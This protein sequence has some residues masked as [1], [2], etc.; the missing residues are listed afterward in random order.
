[1]SAVTVE[2]TI[3]VVDTR[4]TYCGDNWA[5]VALLR[6]LY[7]L[8]TIVVFGSQQ[9]ATTTLPAID[10]KPA[11]QSVHDAAPD[12]NV[13]Y[14]FAGQATHTLAP[15][16]FLCVPPTH[17]TQGPPS[18]PVYP[19]LHVQ[20]RSSALPV[21]SVCMF[22]GQVVHACGPSQFLYV[23]LAHSAH[24]P[25]SGPVNP[26]THE[27]TVIPGTDDWFCAHTVQACTPVSALNV[28]GAQAT[29]AR[30]YTTSN[31]RAAFSTCVNPTLHTQLVTFGAAAGDCLIPA[32]S[33]HA[34]DP[35]AFLY[36]PATHATHTSPV[37]PVYPGA[38]PQSA[39]PT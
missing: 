19:V 32:Q 7:G 1:L 14:V 22:A 39:L 27:H 20:L 28:P 31:V 6:L 37:L 36:F 23:L 15:V 38:H 24:G 8:L 18:A 21:R 10:R 9:S 5:C 3:G 13:E 34:A 12:V 17:A 2:P 4:T 25:P 26:S 30:A 33:T 16:T 29:H 35:L 11:R